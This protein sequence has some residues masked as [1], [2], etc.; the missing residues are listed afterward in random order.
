MAQDDDIEF[1][2]AK[3]KIDLRPASLD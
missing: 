1:E 2:P 3:A